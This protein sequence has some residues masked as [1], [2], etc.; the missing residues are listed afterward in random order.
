[1]S[2]IHTSNSNT[3]RMTIRVMEPKQYIELLA[4]YV[5]HVPIVRRSEAIRHF[6]TSIEVFKWLIKSCQDMIKYRLYVIGIAYLVCTCFQIVK[7]VR[8]TLADD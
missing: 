1:M 4:Q 2:C 6:S 7:K 8:C 3:N 5:T